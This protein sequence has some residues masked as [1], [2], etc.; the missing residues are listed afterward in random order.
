MRENAARVIWRCYKK[1]C[2]K[3]KLEALIEKRKQE[4]SKELKRLKAIIKQEEEE[5]E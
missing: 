1:K 2:D 4:Q 5:L 3:R